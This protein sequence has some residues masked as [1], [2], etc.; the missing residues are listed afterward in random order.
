M[1]NFTKI[2]CAVLALVIALSAASCTLTK[3]YSYKTDDVELSIGVYIY[4]LQNAYSEAQTLAQKSDKYDSEAGTYDGSKSFLKMEITDDD[5][6]TAVAEDWIKDKAAEYM[7]EAVAVYHE[8]NELGATLDEASASYYENMYESYWDSI[9][10]SYE[11]YGISYDSFILAGIT[12][13]LMRS[14]VFEKEYSENGPHAVADDDL[15]KFFNENYTSYKYFSANLYTSEETPVTDAE[16]NESTETTDTAMSDDEVKG[17]QDNFKKYADQISS[18][19]KTISEVLDAYNEAYGAEATLTEDIKK[20]DEDTTDELEKAISALKEGETKS[21]IIGDDANTRQI[22][23]IYRAPISDEK[24]YTK[25]SNNRLSVIS[26]MKTDEFNDL[27]QSIA[28]ELTVTK[29]SAMNSYM[30]S[31]FE[32]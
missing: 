31:M 25:D 18:G 22:Y 4:Y 28:A 21:V 10:E 12:I 27:L 8:Y 1:R 26:E 19:S 13:P 2:L 20:I 6:V 11:K 5:G 3:Q 14:A 23:L 24:D 29:S 15:Q 30:P 9:S 32:N 7:N 17:Y 16:G